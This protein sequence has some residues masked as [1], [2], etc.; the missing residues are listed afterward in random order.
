MKIN[1]ITRT[2]GLVSIKGQKK[3]SDAIFYDKIDFEDIYKSGTGSVKNY[4]TIDANDNLTALVS[5]TKNNELVRMENIINKKGLITTI[6]F[7]ILEHE[8]Q[9]RIRPTED[10]TYA[11]FRWL[12]GVVRFQKYFS[13]TD[14]NGKPINTIELEDDWMDESEKIGIILTKK[15][16]LSEDIYKY[17]NQNYECNL[18]MPM[19]KWIGHRY[20]L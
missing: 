16:K 2:G 19:L 20:L 9:V 4:F 8:K 5:T 15:K 11:G 12:L 13:A 18:I 1:E 7:S 3:P 6:I 14:Y 10:L 17:Q